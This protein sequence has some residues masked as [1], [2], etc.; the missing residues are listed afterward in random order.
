MENMDLT[1]GRFFVQGFFVDEVPYYLF[2]ID[3]S[4]REI[5]ERVRIGN[6]KKGEWDLY[7]NLTDGDI[8]SFEWLHR[9]FVGPHWLVLR[10]IN[11]VFDNTLQ[12]CDNPLNN[13]DKGPAL[14]SISIPNVWITDNAMELTMQAISKN[15]IS[16]QIEYCQDEVGITGIRVMAQIR[17]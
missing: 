4:D 11:W 17:S 6:V 7:V 12:L 15:P 16:A 2:D 14:Q 9:Q 5:M 13:H 3:V 10:K 8:H 1:Q